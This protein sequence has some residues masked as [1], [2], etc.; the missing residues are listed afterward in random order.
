MMFSACSAVQ[1][2]F[3]TITTA[4]ANGL[5]DLYSNLSFLFVSERDSDRRSI[6]RSHQSDTE[7]A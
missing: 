7:A 3:G 4:I 5:V 2:Q 6:D 1:R